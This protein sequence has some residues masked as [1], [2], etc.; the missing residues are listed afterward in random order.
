[1]YEQTDVSGVQW[2]PVP[3]R[4][5]A[6]LMAMVYQFDRSQWQSADELVTNQ[7]RQL[8]RLVSHAIETVP[9]YRERMVHLRDPGNPLALQENWRS[10]PALTRTEVQASASHLSSNRVPKDHGSVH[11]MVTSG[12]TGQP[13]KCLG[14]QITRFFG[15]AS[16]CAIITGIT[17]IFLKPSR[18]YGTP[19]KPLRQ[20]VGRIRTGVR[21]SI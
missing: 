1:M 13:L 9:F 18:Q 7:F 12:S 17:V 19:I 14:T 2:P 10:I 8:S 6:A 4:P 20:M 16:R 3:P 11:S 5:A 15:S 21:R